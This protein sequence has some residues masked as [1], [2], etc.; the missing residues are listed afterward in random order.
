MMGD[1]DIEL[2][3]ASLDKRHAVVVMCQMWARAFGLFERILGRSLWAMVL[4]WA[5][6]SLVD[7]IGGAR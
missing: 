3:P 2:G 1:D 4:V 6:F 7:C 5:G